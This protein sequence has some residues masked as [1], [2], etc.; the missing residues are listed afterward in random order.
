MA[1]ASEGHIAA[2]A[3]AAGEVAKRA[4]AEPV[5]EPVAEL[6]EEP[7]E[8]LVEEPVEGLVEEPVEG[9]AEELAESEICA[10]RSPGVFCANTAPNPEFTPMLTLKTKINPNPKPKLERKL[11]LNPKLEPEPEPSKTP[12]GTYVDLC[13]ARLFPALPGAL[14]II[15]VVRARTNINGV[16]DLVSKGHF[17]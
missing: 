15:A 4:V 7:V 12:S 13:C 17:Q 16:N 2:A 9:L 10:T 1:V 14:P 5:A 11:K 8:E 6:V 3:L